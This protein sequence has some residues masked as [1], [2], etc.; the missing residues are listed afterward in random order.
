LLGAGGT[1]E[2]CQ[3]AAY[4]AQQIVLYSITSS[5]RASSVRAQSIRGY[6][7][8]NS[9]HVPMKA[10]WYP[11]FAQELLSFPVAKNHDQ[12][13]ALASIGWV[14]DIMVPPKLA[15]NVVRLRVRS[16][17]D[18]KTMCRRMMKSPTLGSP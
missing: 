11:A 14:L 1:A 16:P 13:D 7:A 2:K 10:A 17:R 12:V 8:M 18:F 6:I 4:A 15:S 9:L 3:E 5:A